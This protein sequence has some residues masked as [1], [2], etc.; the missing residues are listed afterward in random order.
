MSDAAAD[1][2]TAVG[3]L[4]VGLADSG[5]AALSEAKLGLSAAPDLAPGSGSLLRTSPAS[6]EPL[7]GTAPDPPP[8]SE[9][10]VT[11]GLAAVATSASGA[12]SDAAALLAA[13]SSVLLRS[14][15]RLRG[16]EAP[17]RESLVLPSNNIAAAFGGSDAT[18]SATA[19][20]AP[21]LDDSARE[22]SPTAVGAPAARLA[23]P[24][25]RE[26]IL[27]AR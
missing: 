24:M 15:V 17:S 21:S 27:F 2:T 23:W 14:S 16:T 18:P 6:G 7:A 20:L 11:S 25:R 12:T 4:L 22:V 1:C 5:A 3:A 10:P 8:L 13:S 9:T 19:K 26:D